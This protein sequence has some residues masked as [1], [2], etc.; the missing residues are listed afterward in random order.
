MRLIDENEREIKRRKWKGKI[1]FFFTLHPIYMTTEQKMQTL[2]LLGDGI[3]LPYFNWVWI[4]NEIIGLQHGFGPY[5]VRN[6]GMWLLLCRFSLF[7]R[8]SPSSFGPLRLHQLSLS[9]TFLTF[10]WLS[11]T[12]LALYLSTLPDIPLILSDF[13]C[14]F[15]FAG[16][17]DLPRTLSNVLLVLHFIWLFKQ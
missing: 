1:K 12:L 3:L 8:L 16:P 5:A 14:P 6:V 4:W 17:P 13:A 15:L 9:R 2:L 11:S 10:L 7:I